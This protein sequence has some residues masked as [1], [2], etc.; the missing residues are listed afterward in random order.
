MNKL[1]VSA[2]L[3]ATIALGTVSAS[4]V[5]AKRT[6]SAKPTHGKLFKGRLSYGVA[7]GENLLMQRKY[8][9]AEA[10]FR[11]EARL[12][13]RNANAAA[14]LGMALAMQYKLDGANEQF[15]K[16]LAVDPGNPLAHV[17]KAMVAVNRL[18]SSNKEITDQKESLLAGAENEAREAINSDPQM[19]YAHYALGSVLKEQQKLPEAYNEFKEATNIDP[20]YAEAYAGMA[21]VDLAQNNQA[22]AES[23]AKQAIAL[24]SANSTAHWVLGEVLLQQNNIGGAIK[25][26]NVSLYQFRN[27]APVHL[28]LGKAYE[29]QGNNTAAFKAYEK[30]A[31]IK[32]E[33]KEAYARMASLH[34]ALGKQAEQQ[35]NIVNALKEYRQ[36]TLIDAQNAEPYMHLADLR[37]SRGDLELSVAEL[38]SGLELNPDSPQLHDRIG[39]TLLKLEKTDDAI[40]EFEAALRAQPGNPNT[41]DGL[42]RALYLKAQKE[43]TGSFALSNEYESADAAIKRAIKINPNDLR[44]RLAEA[45]MR[46]LSGDQVDLS[47]IGTPTNDAERIAYAEALLAENKFDDEQNQMKE[48]IAHTEDGK[49][50]AALGDL[51]LMIK[52]LDSAVVAYKKAEQ[53]GQP[54][55]ARRGLLAVEKVRAESKRECNLGADLAKRGMLASSVDNFR[56]A[57]ANNPRMAA[58]RLGL[59]DNEQ[60][61]SPNVPSVLRDAATQYRAYMALETGLPVKEKQKFQKKIERL[62][63]RATKLEQKNIARK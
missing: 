2:L 16:S 21:A 58:P 39:Q 27:S 36:A 46:A 3:S 30:A 59:A 62:E 24:N 60:R 51:S 49:Q 63:A 13:P 57:V 45:K 55:R 17:G 5:L 42:T 43:S 41:L 14:G 19:P 38:R 32:P 53:A 22:G 50:V 40:R 48:V 37:E 11:K 33:M 29:A 7:A 10:T 28:A 34:I 61:L 12:R 54:D 35:H 44:L 4:E 56:L 47:K 1:V 31:L 18:Q 9:E 52:D 8:K 26:L 23:N 25:E 15:D 20:T 6:A